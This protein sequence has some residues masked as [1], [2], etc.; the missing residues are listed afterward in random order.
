MKVLTQEEISSF[1]DDLFYTVIGAMKETE[2][3]V[4]DLGNEEVALAWINLKSSIEILGRQ[5]FTNISS[6]MLAMFLQRLPD[7]ELERYLLELKV[8]VENNMADLKREAGG[9][10]IN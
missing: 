2:E 7:D 4:R 3:R 5:A 1:V 9:F 10:I 6:L 8:K